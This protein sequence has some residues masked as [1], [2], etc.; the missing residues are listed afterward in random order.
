MPFRKVQQGA[1]GELHF[2]QFAPHL[3]EIPVTTEENTAWRPTKIKPADTYVL[4]HSRIAP[5]PK[6]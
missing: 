4:K 1:N 6:G 3:S 2:T 5:R